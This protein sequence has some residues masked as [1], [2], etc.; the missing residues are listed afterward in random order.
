MSDPAVFLSDDLGYLADCLAQNL[1]PPE[2]KQASK[3]F[4]KRLVIVPNQ[5]TKIYLQRRWARQDRLGISAG[6]AII[7]M[8]AAL[9]MLAAD[10]GKVLPSS[11][12]LS[13][14]LFHEAHKELPPELRSYLEGKED[15]LF[16]LC[17]KVARLFLEYGCYCKESLDEWLQKGGWQTHF[18]QAVFAGSNWTF[19]LELFSV[20]KGFDTRPHLFSFFT[21]PSECARYFK[22][23]GSYFY[24]HSPCSEY[25][26]DYLSDKAHAKKSL[27]YRKRKV[28]KAELDAF[29]QLIGAQHPLLA[30]WGQAGSQLLEVLATE[31]MPGDEYYSQKA[32]ER[33]LHHVQHSILNLDTEARNVDPDD[34]LQILAIPSRCREVETLLD[35]LKALLEKRASDA[36]PLMPGEILVLAP[37]IAQYYPYI[38]AYFGSE[39]SHLAYSISGIEKI[40]TSPLAEAFRNLIGLLDKRFDAQALLSLFQSPPFRKK[41]KWEE[42]DLAEVA[43][44]IEKAGITW[45]YDGAQRARITHAS[46]PLEERGSFS[47]GL[48]RLLFGLICQKDVPLPSPLSILD[49]TDAE[50]FEQVVLVIENLQRDMN[51]LSTS[52][53]LSEWT[54]WSGEIFERY[55]SSDEENWLLVALLRLTRTTLCE[56]ILSFTDFCRIADD[57]LNR[58]SGHTPMADLQA[59]RFASLT[60]GEV[61]PA[62]VIVLLG[63]E[64][65]A[66]PRVDSPS[67]LAEVTMQRLSQS[68]CD[69]YLFL[70]ALTK[71][72]EYFW[73]SYVNISP[74]EKIEAM[75]SIVVQEFVQWLKKFFPF[76]GIAITEVPALGITQKALELFPYY[77]VSRYKAAALYHGINATDMAACL[78][79]ELPPEAWP[80]NEEVRLEN[81]NEVLRNSPRFYFS[82]ILR[83]RLK[84][85]EEEDF[86]Q[87]EFCLPLWSK[88]KMALECLTS[89]LEEV[90]T[91]AKY[92]GE[93]PMGEFEKVALAQLEEENRELREKL[94]LFQVKPEECCTLLLSRSCVEPKRLEDGTLLLPA[95]EITF[96][97]RVFFVTGQIDGV[98]PQGILCYEKDKA[99]DL[100]PFWPYYLVL[101]GHPDLQNRK[102]ALLPLGKENKKEE[103]FS[104]G[105]NPRDE[106][107]KLLLYLEKAKKQISPFMAKQFLEFFTPFEKWEKKI[108]GES[109]LYA[110]WLIQQQG[111]AYAKALFELWQPYTQSAF[112]NFYSRFEKKE[113][114]DDV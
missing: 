82:E 113:E 7:E 105:C 93:F 91:R 95:W 100:F 81:L 97:E 40:R 90:V 63:M 4:D 23:S 47:F 103:T 99:P 32:K 29:D 108:I 19:P 41:Q 73:I 6:I 106:M 71:A 57:I 38:Q 1:F 25:W 10:I 111:P 24:L 70:E 30:N 89:S 67:S 39:E 58:K 104:W 64:E 72:S 92:R 5:A 94:A 15:R 54:K 14:R 37:D 55:L 69:R 88:R 110:Q 50:L 45:G 16:P 44:W 36:D 107:G 43:F 101:A 65:G 53:T 60:E 48:D 21:L 85:E 22:Q 61:L 42:G 49:W 84:K 59:V 87:E 78:P 79:A 3:P 68:T 102:A 12:E 11:L 77:S 9:A 76:S 31:E 34:S 13:L 8:H 96:G 109:D 26:G 86:D 112:H 75:P 62:R 98:S 52:R 2:A 28:A 114:R 83:V 33:R 18:W 66:F 17:Q 35:R 74:E 20:A 56:E 27:F 80:E 51:C 46:S